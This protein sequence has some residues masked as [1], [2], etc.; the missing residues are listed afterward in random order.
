MLDYWYPW[1][2]AIFKSDTAHLTAEQ[3][4]IYRRLIDHYM[5]TRQPLPDN[6]HA[7]ARL[8]GVTFECFSPSSNIIR[9]FFKL[10]A[11]KLNHGFCNQQL[12]VQDN[13][14]KIR[15][16]NGKNAAEKRW[17]KPER[18]QSVKWQA[19]SNAIADPMPNDAT[20]QEK[21]GQDKDTAVP[22]GAPVR[23][24][25]L[26]G[27]EVARRAGLEGNPNWFG[28]YSRVEA[29]LQSGFDPELDIYPTV[30][31]LAKKLNR[32]PTNLKYFEQAIADTYASRMQPVKLGTATKGKSNAKPIGQQAA[33]LLESIR[34]GGTSKSSFSDL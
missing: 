1:Y 15:S 12:D 20:G 16:E 28:D 17:K 10:K 23:E 2:P 14:R 25:V 32:P 13:K 34:A 27:K 29:W 9:S 22:A 31:R 19:H 3:D 11:G 33:E 18:K 30:E 5:E 21:T 4:G 6:D 7:L 26:V 24:Y 8:S